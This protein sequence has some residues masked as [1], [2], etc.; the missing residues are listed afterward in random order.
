MQQGGERE[1]EG[2]VAV[3]RKRRYAI[4]P[5]SPTPPRL[6]PSLPFRLRLRLLLS[7]SPLLFPSLPPPTNT[8]PP[9]PPLPFASSSP[10]LASPRRRLLPRRRRRRREYPPPPTPH[11]LLR[12]R[13][14]WFRGEDRPRGSGER[15]C[16]CD[17]DWGLRLQ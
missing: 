14:V 1:R 3:N 8:R 10:R 9:P 11:P 7:G 12:F 4:F 2:R 17:C 6:P 15:H 13:D 16:F 5:E